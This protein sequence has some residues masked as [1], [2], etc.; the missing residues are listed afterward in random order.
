MLNP[1]W[2]AGEAELVIWEENQVLGAWEGNVRDSPVPGG[3]RAEPRVRF[4]FCCDPRKPK[5]LAG[6]NPGTDLKAVCSARDRGRI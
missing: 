4:L 3:A 6:M 1:P 5:P 2:V